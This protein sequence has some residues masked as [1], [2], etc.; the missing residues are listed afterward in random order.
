MTTISLPAA[1][2]IRAQHF[3]LQ[4]LDAVNP[5]RGGGHLGIAFG[6]PMWTAEIETTELSLAQGGSWKWLLARLRGGQRGLYVYDA[7]RTKPL[8]YVDSTTFYDAVLASSTTAYAST[9]WMLASSEGS[10]CIP[11]WGYPK[12]VGVDQANSQLDLEGFYP[13]A[14]ISVGD[15]GAWDDGLARRLHIFGAGTANA[16]TGEVSLDC[17]PAPPASS[18]NLPAALT[19]EKASAEMIVLDAS[20]A[21]SGPTKTHHATLKATQM[22]RRTA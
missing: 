21:F 3:R 2:K 13:G 17:E 12:V 18:A 22:L 16:T 20:V 11:A 14:V 4:R 10:A 5:A 9:T 6:E 7:S 1:A 19:M 8:A 15:Y